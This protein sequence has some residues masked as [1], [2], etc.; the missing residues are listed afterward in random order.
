MVCRN[1]IYD[2]VFFDDKYKGDSVPTL[3]V[4]LNLI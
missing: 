1:K 2:K 4:E 3:D